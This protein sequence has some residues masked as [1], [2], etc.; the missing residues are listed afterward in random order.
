MHEGTRGRGSMKD[1]GI[2]EGDEGTRG[3]QRE[4]RG[5]GDEGA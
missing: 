4:M 1:K 5:Q 2:T 3:S